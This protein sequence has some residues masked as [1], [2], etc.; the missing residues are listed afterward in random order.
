MLK[1]HDGEFD[2]AQATLTTYFTRVAKT[3]PAGQKAW[4]SYNT[5]TYS[6]FS[7]VGGQLGFCQTAGAI[8]RDVVFT[9]RGQFGALAAQRMQELRNSLFG[10]W[11]EQALPGRV[12]HTRSGSLPNLDARCWDK[13]GYWVAKKCGALAWPPV[14]AQ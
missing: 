6:S 14:V 3:K 9:P 8:G 1:D 5:K 13:K 4:D 11:G 12:A 7:T 2:G 10:A